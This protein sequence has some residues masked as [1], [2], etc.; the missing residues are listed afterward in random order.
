MKITKARLRQIIKEELLKEFGYD[1]EL[2]NPEP[3]LPPPYDEIDK[4]IDEV[5]EKIEAI[6]EPLRQLAI[7][8]KEAGLP[9]TVSV[10]DHVL[11]TI[12][13]LLKNLNGQHKKVLKKA[14]VGQVKQD[15]LDTL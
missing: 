9:E 6:D 11:E 8:V 7:Q 12:L 3:E 15:Y 13:T 5:Y 1:D 4:K 10:R 14:L 2:N